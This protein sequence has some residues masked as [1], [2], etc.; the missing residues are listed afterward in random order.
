MEQGPQIEILIKFCT[1]ADMFDAAATKCEGEEV[2][3]LVCGPQGLQE[4]V[5]S[6]CSSQN[7]K[8]HWKT[9][10]HFHSVSFDL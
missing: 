6:E 7:F 1:C 4:S 10:F 2:G 3:V 5:A 8:S 9:Q